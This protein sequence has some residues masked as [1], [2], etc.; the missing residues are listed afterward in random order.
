MTQISTVSICGTI[1]YRNELTLRLSNKFRIVA[2]F[3]F[4]DIY[5]RQMFDY[6]PVYSYENLKTHKS[7]YFVIAYDD[8]TLIEKTKNVL[9]SNGISDSAIVIYKYFANTLNFDVLERFGQENIRFENLIFG[10]SHAKSDIS[11]SC[12]LPN[13]FSFAAPSMDMFCHY[14]LLNYIS[15]HYPNSVTAIKNIYIELP[16]YVFNYDLS[17]FKDFFL[18][19]ISYFDKLGDYHNF[20]N[21]SLINEYKVFKEMFVSS[22]SSQSYLSE[23]NP[24]DKRYKIKDKL[25]HIIDMLK[26]VGLHDKVWE[27]DFDETKEENIKIFKELL[28]LIKR[29]YDDAHIT[30]IVL[31]YNPWFRYTHRKCIKRR[32]LEFY[33]V[34]DSYLNELSI[35]DMFNDVSSTSCFLDHCHLKKE[36]STK[37]TNRLVDRI[38]Q[39]NS[40]SN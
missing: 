2:Y 22:S 7:D 1:H 10:M 40:K 17:K 9:K 30:L 32:K 8:I 12:F 3:E 26:V 37:W 19:K 15:L 25:Y 31:P 6:K 36:Y 23:E 13:T 28:S 24:C 34:V 29:D 20:D 33:T 27:K 4:S 16:Y 11:I 38:Y 14:E 5:D 39:I 18:T 35:I 21:H